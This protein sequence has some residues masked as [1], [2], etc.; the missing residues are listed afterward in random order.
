MRFE[1]RRTRHYDNCVHGYIYNA[2]SGQYFCYSLESKVGLLPEGEYS[3]K[4]GVAGNCKIL[5][6]IIINRKVSDNSINVSSLIIGGDELK[7]F[8]MGE[9]LHEIIS[10]GEHI[11]KILD[12]DF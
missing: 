10:K 8:G 1:L 6:N 2:D 7:I 12:Y 4:D 11:I 5:G 9:E 3:I